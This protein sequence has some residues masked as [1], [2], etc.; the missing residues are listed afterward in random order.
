MIE[1][2]SK[3]VQPMQQIADWL[4]K[5]TL[6]QYAQRFAENDV[7]FSVLRYLTDAD[8]EKIGV[9]DIAVKF[10]QLSP[11]YPAYLCHK[12][13]PLSARSRNLKKLRSAVT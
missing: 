2:T 13:R 4:E 6:G 7:D 9:S 8:L 5:L 12:M 10:W 3:P 11:S 1:A